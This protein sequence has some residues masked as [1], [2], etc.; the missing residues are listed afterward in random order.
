MPVIVILSTDISR[1]FRK[2]GDGS[3]TS[4]KAAAALQGALGSLGR[5]LNPVHPGTVDPE[6][7]RHFQLDI[8]DRGQAE[9]AAGLLRGLDGVEAAY[10]K[11][12]AE[13]P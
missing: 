1:H 12:V 8:D 10:W 7:S 2:D 11:P 4:D 9:R 5:V 6:L 13:A 3:R